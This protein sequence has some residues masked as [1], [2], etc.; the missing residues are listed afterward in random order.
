MSKKK[1]YSPY[2]IVRNAIRKLWLQSPMRR[3]AVARATVKE[4]YIKKDGSVGKKMRIVGYKCEKCGELLTKKEIN[5]H[6][7]EDIPKPFEMVFD[8]FIKK[9]FCPPEGLL[10]LCKPC[11]KEIHDKD[12][13]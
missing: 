11:H 8:D 9:M 7:I 3:D 5:V 2:P 10:V 12:N 13:N 4:P 1:K 6:H